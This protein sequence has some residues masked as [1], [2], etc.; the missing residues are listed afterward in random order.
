[1]ADLVTETLTFSSNG[2][3]ADGYLALPGDGAA[4]P[5]VIVIQEWWGVDDHI[6]DLARRFARAGYVALA[7]DL[8]HGAVVPLGEPNLAE[9][10]MMKMDL[11]VVARDLAGALHALQARADVSPK[12][13]GV[14]GFCMGGLLALSFA[15]QAGDELGAAV[16]FYSFGYQ[17]TPEGV[18]AMQAPVLAIFASEDGSMPEEVRDRFRQ[19]LAEHGKTFDIVVY[20]GADHAFFNDRRPEVYNASAAADAW[21]RTLDWFARYLQ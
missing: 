8:Y 12:K 14:V 9:K 1:M 5:G 21:Q 4:H 16:S 3:T 10:E 18:S 6:K 19:M 2:G 7:P 15:S 20:Q 13:I 11:A 17:P